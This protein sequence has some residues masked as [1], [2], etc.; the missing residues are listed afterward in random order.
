VLKGCDGGNAEDCG[1]G[2]VVLGVG[3]MVW[4]CFAVV[5]DIGRVGGDLILRRK[6]CE[7]AAA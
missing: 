3:D 2:G 7:N 5:E 1:A 6:N 4:N